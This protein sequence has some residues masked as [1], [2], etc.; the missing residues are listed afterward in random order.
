MTVRLRPLR[1]EEVQEFIDELRREYVRGLIEDASMT[2]EQAEEKAANDHA[3]LFPGGSPQ[4][5][6]HMYVLEGEAGEPVGH[7]FWAKRQAP[8]GAA[9]RAF[10]YQIYIDEA[11]RG[12][13]L[14]RQA[15]ELLETEVRDDGLPGI[16]LNVWG[17]NDPARSLYRSLGYE[18]LAVF[19]S[20]ELG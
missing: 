10:L 11:F 5:D 7:L 1:D 14:G 8:G 2:R 15:L 20:K 13:G 17:G 12:R 3:S 4:P 19:M 6:H 16:D 9:T 18:E